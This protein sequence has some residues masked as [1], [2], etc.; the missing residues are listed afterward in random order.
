LSRLVFGISVPCSNPAP[1]SRWLF[2][3]ARLLD[4]LCRGRLP[5]V[6]KCAEYHGRDGTCSGTLDLDNATLLVSLWSI[7]HNQTSSDTD[8]VS[9]GL[10][11]L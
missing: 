1:V 8:A 2:S 6:D 5:A 11:P 7:S 9:T 10:L 3:Q 4:E